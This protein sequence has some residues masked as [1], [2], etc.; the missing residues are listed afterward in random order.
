[1][2]EE[3]RPVEIPQ[4]DVDYV[5]VDERTGE[6]KFIG[7]THKGDVW[8]LPPYQ[9]IEPADAEDQVEVSPKPPTGA[10]TRQIAGAH[11]KDMP[12]QPVEFCQRNRLG[13][14]EANVVKYVC[15]HRIKRGRED[16][17]K[18][19]HYIDLLLDL[20]YGEGEV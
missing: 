8:Q 6:R 2:A 1:M 10:M 4:D 5:L 11:Y 20:E 17:E 13:Y 14:C 16:L 19:K 18:A 3:L 7:G 15:R 9:R 12:I